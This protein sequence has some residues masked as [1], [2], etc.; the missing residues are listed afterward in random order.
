MLAPSAF[1]SC[2]GSRLLFATTTDPDS[3]LR[4]GYLCC[5]AAAPPLELLPSEVLS[6]GRADRLLP[7]FLCGCSCLPP[8]RGLLSFC[9]YALRTLEVA[10]DSCEVEASV[11]EPLRFCLAPRFGG[12]PGLRASA[13]LD[14]VV[15]VIRV[16]MRLDRGALLVDAAGGS[17]SDLDLEVPTPDS[18][19]LFS[20]LEREGLVWKLDRKLGITRGSSVY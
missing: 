1:L 11:S 5:G 16:G 13:L 20:R 15:R 7:H 9:R 4:S 10:T 3:R 12:T 2:A 8:D 18:C 19:A 14:R 6:A 17:S